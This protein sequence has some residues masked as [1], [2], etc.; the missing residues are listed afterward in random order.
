MYR[1]LEIAAIMLEHSIRDHEDPCADSDDNLFRCICRGMNGYIQ[2]SPGSAGDTFCHRPLKTPNRLGSAVQQRD[3]VIQRPEII[4][5]PDAE[6]AA[7]QQVYYS[8]APL[9]HV[10]TVYAQ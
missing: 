9:P 8:R 10:E 3:L 6:D 4:K 2:W 7:R 1:D 5:I